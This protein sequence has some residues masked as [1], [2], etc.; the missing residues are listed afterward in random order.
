VA[1]VGWEGLSAR[2]RDVALLVAHGDSN[3]G[4]ARAL[5]LSDHT[6]RAHVSRVLAAFGAAS[7]LVVVEV[8]ADRI[9]AE[10]TDVSLTP[11]QRAVA[12]AVA[13]GLGNAAIADELRISVKTVEKHLADIRSRW[14]VSTRGEVARL[15]RSSGRSE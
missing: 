12:D 6:V 1:G 15:A 5:H 7:R 3:S 11:R 13:R 8:L 10:G 9:P 4:I 14:R 2:E